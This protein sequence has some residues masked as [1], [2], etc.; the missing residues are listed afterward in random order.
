[1]GFGSRQI[2]GQVT[3]L[4]SCAK[5]GHQ[6]QDSLAVVVIVV[7]AVVVVVVMVIIM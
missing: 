2:T 7:V 4:K 6:G 3:K 5:E 1:M